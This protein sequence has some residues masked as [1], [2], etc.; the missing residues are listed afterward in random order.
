MPTTDIIPDS[1][2]AAASAI[3][4]GQPIFMLN[5]LRYRDRAA[6]DTGRDA[7]PCS[8]REAYHQRYAPAFRQLATPDIKVFWLGTA[9]AHMVAPPDEHW[10]EVAIIEYPSF[11]AFRQVVDSPQYR[12]D[13]RPHRLAALADWRLIAMSRLE[14]R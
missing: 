12:S 14:L 3:P 8:G 10:H 7:A 9:V 11:A 1:L 2:V 6:Y 4:A 5:L 13:A